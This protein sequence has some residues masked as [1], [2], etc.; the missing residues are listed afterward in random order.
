MEKIVI[1]IG[2]NATQQLTE[3][4]FEQLA[5]WQQQGKQVIIIHGG[6]PQIS[7]WSSDLGLTVTKKNGIRV[8]DEATLKVTQAVLLGVVQPALFQMIADHGFEVMGLNMADN[9]LLE[10]EY[11]DQP[12][13]GEVGQVTKVNEEWLAQNLHG[14]I[15]VIAPLVQTAHSAVLNVNADVAAAKIAEELNAEELVLL[16]DVP[17]VIKDGNVISEL[18]NQMAHSLMQDE[19]IKSGMKPKIKAAFTALEH[20]VQKVLITDNIE[21]HGT[22]LKTA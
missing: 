20:G 6:G 15:A 12:L 1:K 3:S 11:V 16:T 4:F 13:Y 22:V 19:I 7:K 2:G 18:N 8:T 10:G 5:V 9:H 21:N 14:Q 17:G